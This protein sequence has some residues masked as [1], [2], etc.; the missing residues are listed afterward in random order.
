MGAQKT[1][2][3]LQSFHRLKCSWESYLKY[4]L[5][6]Y[7]IADLSLIQPLGVVAVE[8]IDLLKS[9]FYSLI[10][11]LVVAETD[12]RQILTLPLPVCLGCAFRN[13]KLKIDK[14]FKVGGR[15]CKIVTWDMPLKRD[16]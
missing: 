15:S 3:L 11:S 4:F 7:Q 5:S 1:V 8:L 14:V 16:H 10:E 13:A 6:R 2:L 9:A 12:L